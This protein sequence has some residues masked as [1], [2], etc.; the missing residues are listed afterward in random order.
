MDGHV[1]DRA[2]QREGGIV[3]PLPRTSLGRIAELRV[4][5]HR[6]A[7]ASLVDRLP[8]ALHAGVVAHVLGHAEGDAR[9]GLRGQH[10]L[11]LAGVHRQ[12]LLA[13]HRLAVLERE[14]NVVQ[15]QR[16]G[17]GDEDRVD[18]GRGAQG[19]GGLKNMCDGV[20]AG[21]RPPL[22]Q[23]A[24]PEPHQARLPRRGEGGNQPL[25]RM[26]PEAENA[27]ANHGSSG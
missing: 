19:L 3:D 2:A 14:Q 8:H 9:L 4:G 7:D 21:V 10:P 6:L 16:V 22:G 12:R 13:K 27:V 1:A 26:V 17:R 23:V 5:K 25:F 18:L 11:D 20:V 15:M 24:P